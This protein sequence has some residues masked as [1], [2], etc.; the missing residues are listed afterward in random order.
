MDHTTSLSDVVVGN[1]AKGIET[2]EGSEGQDR[3]LC[4]PVPPLRLFWSR[5]WP[6]PA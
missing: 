1:K 5:P 2:I 6:V 4:P 3:L